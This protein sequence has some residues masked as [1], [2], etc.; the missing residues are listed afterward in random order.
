M[1]WIGRLT[2]F[3]VLFQRPSASLVLTTVTVSANDWH[4]ANDVG[5]RFSACSSVNWE[6][7]AALG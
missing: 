5:V 2:S 6:V 4:Y 3:L 7:F 1:A